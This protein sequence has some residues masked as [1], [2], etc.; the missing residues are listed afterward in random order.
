[1]NKIKDKKIKR[2]NER[3]SQN[4]LI[5]DGRRIGIGVRIRT[6]L[7]PSVNQSEASLSFKMEESRHVSDKGIGNKIY[8]SC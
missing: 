4:K 6:T 1:M 3:V 2:A 7:R 8:A 5:C